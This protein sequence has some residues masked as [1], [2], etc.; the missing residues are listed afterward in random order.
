MG[1][2]KWF[3]ISYWF[4]EF[5]EFLIPLTNFTQTKQQHQEAQKCPIHRETSSLIDT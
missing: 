4:C 2:K 3:K 1:F 5:L